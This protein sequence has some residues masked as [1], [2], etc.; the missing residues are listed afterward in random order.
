MTSPPAIVSSLKSNLVIQGSCLPVNKLSSWLIRSFDW[1]VGEN[2]VQTVAVI[3][4]AKHLSSGMSY[5]VRDAE[6]CHQLVECA[7]IGKKPP[8]SRRC[9]YKSTL[10]KQNQRVDAAGM[11]THNERPP[12]PP[13]NPYL[14]ASKVILSMLS[15]PSRTQGV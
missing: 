5:T 12:L 7:I 6:F 14:T 8:I 1:Q 3:T 4:P 2:V 11:G 10:L 13:N 15:A 9:T